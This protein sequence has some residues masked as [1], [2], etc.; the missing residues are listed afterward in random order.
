[1]HKL[2]PVTSVDDIPSS[3]R[4][5]PIQTLFECHNFGMHKDEEFAQAQMLIGMCMDNRKNLKMPHNFAFI[6]RDGGA[7]FRQSEF[8]IS[9][10]VAVGGIRCIALIGHTQCGMVN[11][12]DRKKLFTDGLVSAGWDPKAADEHFEQSA[13]VFEIR[14]ETDFIINEVK[15][16]RRRYPNVLV[17]PLLYKVEDST[18][19]LIAENT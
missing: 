8:K 6:L 11:L 9:Y 18:L 14:N 13:P 19:Y 3:Y 1:M 4:N 15:R 5:T 12:H 10:A 16:L 17:A 7:N 2:L